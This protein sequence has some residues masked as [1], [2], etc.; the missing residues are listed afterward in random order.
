MRSINYLFFFLVLISFFSCG[1]NKSKEKKTTTKELF[2]KYT[3]NRDLL[4]YFET[5]FQLKNENI[6]NDTIF[7]IPLNS[8]DKCVQVIMA[9]IEENDFSGLIV[10]GGKISDKPIFNEMYQSLL[11]TE[12]CLIDT[13][14]RMYQYNLDVYEPALIITNSE[15]PVMANLNYLTWNETCKQIGW[16][17]SAHSSTDK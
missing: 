7:F 16:K 13:N 17:I 6:A 3:H 9:S 2:T 12:H 15:K 11:K 1:P 8:C 4:A 5:E 10:F 14:Y